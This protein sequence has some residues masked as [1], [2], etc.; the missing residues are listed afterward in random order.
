MTIRT[1]TLKLWVTVIL[2]SCLFTLTTHA[3]SST[4]G[5]AFS[6]GGKWVDKVLVEAE[7]RDGTV[8]LTFNKQTGKA[9]LEYEVWDSM[10]TYTFHS[11]TPITMDT[12]QPL[13][14]DYTYKE[15]TRE[16]EARVMQGTGSLQL[17]SGYIVL[18]MGALPSDLD[19]VYVKPRTFIRDPYANR[20]PKP[21]DDFQVVSKAC[22]CKP[23]NLVSF[24]YPVAD[25]EGNKEWVRYVSVHVRGIFLAEYK[26]NL[27]T[28]QASKLTDS[29]AEA[30]QSFQQGDVLSIKA[31]STL[32]K[33]KA[34]SY[35][36]SQVIDGDSATCWCEGV[37]GNGVGQSFT[38][39]FKKAIEIQSLDILPGYGKSVSAYL[40]NN[41][42]RRA[43]ITFSDG[44]SITADFSKTSF[45]DLPVTKETTSLT[46]T[47]LEVFPGSKYNDTCVSEME[48]F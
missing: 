47:I 6:Y 7:D 36:A 13:K 15:Y 5:T 40:E 46:F 48:I 35:E 17:K 19:P 14:F 11:V 39:R 23:S 3:A 9:S 32:H 37:K 16:G 26:V 33:S 38:I 10:E 18:Q 41:S 2:L 1:F 20:A 45:V 24:D 31:S 42:V 30:S 4:A 27:H 8:S 22:G 12:V 29:G 34:A 43:K 44:T 28:Y 25:N 21:G